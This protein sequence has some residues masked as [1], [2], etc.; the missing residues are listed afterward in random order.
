MSGLLDQLK[1][2]SGIGHPKPWRVPPLEGFHVGTLDTW[3]DTMLWVAI[4]HGM[5]HRVPDLRPQVQEQG[6]SVGGSWARH[7]EPGHW[8]QTSQAG[9]SAP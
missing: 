9:I 7:E 8:A 4:H 1:T 5:F 6:H 3:G 2:S